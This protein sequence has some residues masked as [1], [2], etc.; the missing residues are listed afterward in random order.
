MSEP[1]PAPTPTVNDMTFNQLS[2]VLNSIASQATGKAQ[3]T[4]VNTNEFVSLAQTTLKTGYDPV[5][6]AVSQVLSRTIFSNRPY[7]AKFRGLMADSIRYGNHVRKLQVADGT[8]RDDDRYGLTDGYSV[9]QQIVCKPNV[10][11]TNFYGTNVWEKC[12]TIFK[13]QLDCAFSSEEEFRRFISMTQQNVVDM[14]EQGREV[15]A[16]AS[17]ANFIGA[18]I[19]ADEDNVIHLVTEFATE[20]GIEDGDEDTV[21]TTHFVEFMKWAFA[22]IKTISDRMTE[23]SII[24]HMNITDKAISRHTPYSMQKFYLYSPIINQI[25]STVLSSVYN[26][27][28]LRM[29]DHEKVNYWQSIL[30]PAKI[31]VVPNY[32]SSSGAVTVAESAVVQ[33]MV[34]G[35]LFDE[36]AIGYTTINQWSQPAPFNARGGYTTIWWHESHRYWNDLT[37]NAVVFL[38]D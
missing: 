6:S 22:R 30:D 13:D 7:S 19:E 16:R 11:Q 27:Q 8:F 25:D 31:S 3:I 33:D 26:D 34:F 17:L 20:F 14:L 10:L 18:K 24:Y 5:L 21:L 4:P 12:L 38:L 1:S 29:A 32:I 15:T 35:I 36:E 2:T 23:R 9:D 37:E 28:Y